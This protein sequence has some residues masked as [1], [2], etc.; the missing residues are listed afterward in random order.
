MR[1]KSLIGLV[2]SLALAALSGCG[3]GGG[4]AEPAAPTTTKISGMAS[5]GPIRTGTVKVFA[6]RGGAEDRSAPLA[7]GGTDGGG[8][9]SIDLGAYSGPVLVEVS[10]GSYED[11]ANPGT[12]VTLKAPMR[13]VFSNATTGTKTVAVTPLTELAYKKA[14]GTGG[15][16]PTAIDDANANISSFFKL[17]DIVSTLPVAG[18]ASDEQ[19]KYAFACGSFSQLVSDNRGTGESLDDAL[20]RVITAMGDEMEQKGGLT[21]DSISRINGAITTFSNSGKNRSGAT[22]PTLPTPTSGFLKLGT[23][24]T[25]GT[26]AAVDMS[27][28]LPAGVKVNADAITGEVSSGVITISGVAA[29]GD[30]KLVSARFIP[31]A[32]GA[33]AQLRIALINATGFGPGEFLTIRFDLDTGGGFPAGASAFSVAGFSP[34]GL[35]GETL[36][37]ITAAPASVSAEIK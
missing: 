35:N 10:G 8:N 19:K 24:G 4:G 28:I 23:S 29:A 20:Q 16:T 18:G 22:I 9:Y 11:E 3:G 36:D 32:G 33:P 25:A 2:L 27:V 14:L 17:A 37:G 12:T 31:A 5:K 1:V 26:I 7:Q 21:E 15:L 30:S 34:K 13:A 6:I